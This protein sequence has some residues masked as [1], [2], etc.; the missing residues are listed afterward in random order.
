MKTTHQFKAIV[1]A[2]L[3][4]MTID[5]TLPQD[6]NDLDIDGVFE[7]AEKRYGRQSM[8]D[9][10]A[11]FVSYDDLEDLENML[12]ILENHPDRSEITGWIEGITM[13]DRFETSFTVED[14]LTQIS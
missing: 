6:M 12:S 10:L 4:E 5:C 3:C 8:L 7:E 14:L 13:V 11:E 2:I 1:K 9:N